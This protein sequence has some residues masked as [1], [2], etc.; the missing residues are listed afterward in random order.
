MKKTR[1]LALFLCVITVL[2]SVSCAKGTGASETTP[3]AQ[4]SDSSTLPSQNN[5]AGG[6]MTAPAE[7]VDANGFLLDDLDPS[8]TFGGEEF[9][10]LYWSDREREEFYV[11]NLTGDLVND[12]LY[13]RNQ[14]V[15]ERLGIT[16]TYATAKGNGSNV[17]PFAQK[18]STSISAG[19]HAYD[20]IAAHSVTIGMCAAQRLLYNL[21][22]IDHLDFDK[23]WWP[24]TLID[25]ATVNDKLY[26]ASGDI[27]AN[28]LYKMYVTFFNKEMLDSYQLENPYDLVNSGKWTIDK[29]ISM[30]TDIYS[31]TD[32]NGSKNVCDQ[33]GLYAY[34]LHADAFL[35]GSDIITLDNVDGMLTFTE[36]FL[37]EKTQNL[38]EKLQNFFRNTNDAYLLTANDD[39]S[40]Y[41]RTGL[42]LFW[43]DR[44]DKAISFSGGDISYGIIPIPMYDE[45]QE[46]YRTLLG[47]PFSLYALPQDCRKPDVL[48]AVMECMASESYRT[49]SPALYELSLKVKYSQDDVAAQMY[50]IARN[51]VIFDL[52]R[53]FLNSL[54]APYERWQEALV[55]N[56]AWMTKSKAMRNPWSKQAAK[57]LEIYE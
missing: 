3:T 56:V 28:V 49:V 20:M 37:G 15:E 11:E 42:S 33:Y 39:T 45:E 18:V 30:C 34:T 44:C 4:N 40:Q 10:L 5:N 29:M 8:L 31:D 54:S 32:G 52:G 19:D 47:N 13:T 21:H 35:A 43:V 48:G 50:D 9:T 51:T 14:A 2:I 55:G 41:F 24:D 7:R 46:S 57:L 17:A 27:S 38:Q 23:P 6:D 16:F 22:E 25:E 26:F 36:D 53:I 1:I 12:A